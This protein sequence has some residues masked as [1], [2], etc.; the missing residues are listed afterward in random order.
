MDN[1]SSHRMPR[2]RK[3]LLIALVLMLFALVCAYFFT[4]RGS[5]VGD[6]QNFSNGYF[7]INHPASLTPKD[8][9]QTVEFKGQ[10]G[11]GSEE[12]KQMNVLYKSIP[13]DY[14][15]NRHV[16]RITKSLSGKSKDNITVE[17]TTVSSKEALISLSKNAR[18]GGSSTYNCYII[19]DKKL[20]TIQF[21][22]NNNENSKER[23]NQVLNTFKF[24]ES[25]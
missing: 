21:V 3:I 11:S 7:S 16:A 6:T 22:L 23:A 1:S 17:R 15:L 8:N 25:S 10:G 2:G 14:S 20:W 5:S 12:I 24:I 13:E 18:N 9:G 4:R 19:S